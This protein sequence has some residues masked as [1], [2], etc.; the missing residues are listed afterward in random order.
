MERSLCAATTTTTMTAESW[1]QCP[2]KGHDATTFT[3]HTH[4]T[5]YDLRSVDYYIGRDESCMHTMRQQQQI[6]TE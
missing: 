6:V 5:P 1:S 2:A 4:I 3:Q